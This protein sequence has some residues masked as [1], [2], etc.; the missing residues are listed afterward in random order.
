MVFYAATNLCYVT[1]STIASS[2]KLSPLTVSTL[3]TKTSN[4]IWSVLMR[5]GFLDVPKTE[6]QRTLNEIFLV[7]SVPWREHS[8]WCKLLI[9]PG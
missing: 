2:Y 5:G 8:L 1:Q 6:Y 7:Q 9:I 3:I 4:V